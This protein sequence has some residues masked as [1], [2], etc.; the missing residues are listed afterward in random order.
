MI[1]R[2]Y[3]NYNIILD[4]SKQLSYNKKWNPLSIQIFDSTDI[5]LY[6]MDK[7]VAGNSNCFRKNAFWGGGFSF[8]CLISVKYEN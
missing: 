4:I 7:K 8:W 5:Y 3:L 6:L 1:N 2:Y